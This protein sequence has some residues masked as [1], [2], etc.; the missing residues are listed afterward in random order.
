[1]F[2]GT[3]ELLKARMLLQ[4]EIK[5][6]NFTWEKNSCAQLNY[7]DQWDDL[8]LGGMCAEKVRIWEELEASLMCSFPQLWLP[9]SFHKDH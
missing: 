9:K 6:A 1:M 3:G 5:A 8:E 2:G 4:H 7:I